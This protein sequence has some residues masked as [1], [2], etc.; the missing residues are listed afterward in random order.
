MSSTPMDCIGR[1][2]MVARLD[3]KWSMLAAVMVLDAIWM[4]SGRW[5]IQLE[6]V[7]TCLLFVLAF[8]APLA[9]KR[10][11]QSANTVHFCEA[12]A[13]SIL[14]AKSAAVLSYLVVSTNFPLV[15]APLAAMDK[16]LGFDWPSYDRWVV[17][18][19]YYQR[20]IRFAYA[21]MANQIWLVAAFLSFTGR[22]ARLRVFLLLSSTTLLFA[23]FA[24]LFFPAASAAKYFQAQTHMAVPGFSQFEPLRAGTLTTIDLNAMQGLVSMP[25]FH[26]IMAILF[27][28][29]VRRTPAAFVLIPLNIALVLATPTEGGHY[30]VDVIAGA[31][32]AFGAIAVLDRPAARNAAGL[33]LKQTIA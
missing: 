7:W 21:S 3:L 20:A 26:T 8:V 11:R 23:I 24:A 9:F 2:G 10:L 16:W 17:A 28:W 27:C 25:S 5:S 12:T 31:V 6:S 30:L 33:E 32:V 18:H 13:F 1:G 22:L 14:F 4:I 15:D 29:A 19:P